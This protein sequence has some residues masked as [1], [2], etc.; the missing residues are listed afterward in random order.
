[1]HVRRGDVGEGVAS[2]LKAQSIINSTVYEHHS[3]LEAPVRESVA[4]EV[5]AVEVTIAV[6]EHPVVKRHTNDGVE[7][8]QCKE[9]QEDCHSCP[10][11]LCN[12]VQVVEAMSAVMQ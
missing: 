8:R 9:H 10:K 4:L 7:V 3:L 12:E 11:R 2:L 1:L 5:G 6:H